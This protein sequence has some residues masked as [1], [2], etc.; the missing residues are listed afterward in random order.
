MISPSEFFQVAEDLAN[1]PD[2]EEAVFR[3]SI[4]RAYYAAFHE[5]AD[6]YAD[7]KKVPR[8]DRLFENHQNFIRTLRELRA[9]PKF[10]KLG[11]QLNDLKSDRIKADYKLHQ[12]ISRNTAKKSWA[13]SR[14]IFSGCQNL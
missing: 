1:S 10:K 3:T 4:S 9:E 6:A 11:N 8:S 12:D 2:D 13:A 7:K 14:R 5:V